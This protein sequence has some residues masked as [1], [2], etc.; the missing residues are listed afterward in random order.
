MTF[1]LLAFPDVNIWIT[2]GAGPDLI[3]AE[4]IKEKEVN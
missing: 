3:Q 1:T 2:Y 4:E